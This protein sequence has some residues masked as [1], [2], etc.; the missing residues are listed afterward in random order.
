MNMH[1]KWT[2]NLVEI[3][4][5]FREGWIH[6]ALKQCDG[7]SPKV[8]GNGFECRELGIIAE[9]VEFN[10]ESEPAQLYGKPCNQELW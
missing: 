3:I 4:W 9:T 6:I 1:R 8:F 10:W 5:K 2:L 7:L